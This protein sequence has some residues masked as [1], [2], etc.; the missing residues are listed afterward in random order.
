[1]K[2]L[3]ADE[4]IQELRK[5]LINLLKEYKGDEK[6]KLNIPHELLEM[7]IFNVGINYKCFSFNF[8][9]IKKL[10]LTDV[11]FDNVDIRGL[12]FSDSKGVKIN[13]QTIYE[14]NMFCTVLKDVEI[15]GSLDYV[16]IRCTNFAGSKGAK[17]NPQTIYNRNMSGAVLRD[18]EIIGPLDDICITDTNFDGCIQT[19]TDFMNNGSELYKKIESEL[20]RVLSR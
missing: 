3:L 14:R 18:A 16:Y 15:T 11:L 9:L 19:N 6:I 10:D 4:H 13:P 5:G 2:K 17:I 20:K 1:M 8:E 7:L 12:D